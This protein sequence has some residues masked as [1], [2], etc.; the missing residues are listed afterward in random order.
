MGQNLANNELLVTVNADLSKLQNALKEASASINQLKKE[1]RASDSNIF[2]IFTGKLKEFDSVAGTSFGRVGDAVTGL[3]S[4]LGTVGLAV[5]GLALAAGGIYSAFSFAQIGEELEKK[6][7]Q[8]DTLAASAGIVGQ[9]LLSGLEKSA[10]GLTDTD[11]LINIANGS[12]LKLGASAKSLPELFEIAQ[13]SVKV[14]GGD[15][16]Q[17]LEL[18]SNA[19][20]NLQTRQLKSIGLNVDAE[21]TFKSYAK[22]IGVTADQLTEAEKKQALLNAVLEAGGERFKDISTGVGDSTISNGLKRISVGFDS[23]K[24]AIAGIAYTTL[25]KVFGEV[26]NGI[27]SAISNVAE[28]IDKLTGKPQSIA[29]QLEDVNQQLARYKELQTL[30]PNTAQIYDAEIA[31]LEELKKSLSAVNAEKAVKVEGEKGNVVR[32]LSDQQL[33]EQEAARD[34]ALAIQQEQFALEQQAQIDHYAKLAEIADQDEF[35]KEERANVAFNQT[36]QRNQLELDNAKAKAETIKNEEEKAAALS[37]ANAKKLAADQK[38]IDDKAL[39]DKTAQAEKKKQIEQAALATTGAVIQAGLAF[40]QQGSAAAKG[41][42]VADAV[43]NTYVGANLA[44]AS[45]PPPFNFIQ[46]AAVIATGI[47][48]VSKITAANSG[49]LV[50]TGV[51]GQD[52]NPFLLSKGEIVAPA[53]SFDEVVEGT[54]RA[55]GFVKG[56]DNQEVIQVLNQ[57]LERLQTPS[58]IVNSDFLTDDNSINRLAERLREAVQFR[59]AQLG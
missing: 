13:K 17:N 7:S 21:A 24:D 1:T 11:D 5:G 48:N 22:S 52:T 47:A 23:L 46:A 36:V 31:K 30:N 32:E 27:G 14:F 8:F 44:L 57:I 26:L 56:D 12:I 33:K 54:A 41:L 50:T 51:A 6:K 55:R 49:A 45:S 20:G 29:K 9:E 19:I 28:Q 35:T 25:G 10:G 37:L 39:A 40:A 16:T 59:D 58:I 42:Q 53:K 2:D 4:K 3:G 34:R 18:I 38:A 43:R 15:S